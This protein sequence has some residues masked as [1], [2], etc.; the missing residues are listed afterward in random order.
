MLATT[1]P[2]NSPVYVVLRLSAEKMAGKFEGCAL[3]LKRRESFSSLQCSRAVVQFYL[4]NV[5]IALLKI[6]LTAGIVGWR[7]FTN[8]LWRCEA[9]YQHRR[10]TTTDS[11][12]IASTASITK[13]AML[14][15]IMH[16]LNKK[17]S[18]IFFSWRNNG[19]WHTLKAS[20]LRS[21]PLFFAAVGAE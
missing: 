19:C 13:S 16:I 1:S 3:T 7:L 11:T 15:K 2:K 4:T 6:K 9:I 8:Y 17:L 5:M 14:I 12:S 10:F 18:C 21:A 20:R